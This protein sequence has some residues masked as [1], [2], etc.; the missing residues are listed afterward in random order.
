LDERGGAAQGSEAVAVGAQ[1]ITMLRDPLARAVSQFEH[2]RSRGRFRGPLPRSDHRGSG[3]AD[4]GD[5]R[6]AALA[7]AVLRQLASPQTCPQLETRPSRQCASLSN[8]AKC[9]ANGWCGLFQDHQVEC[10]AGAASF[11]SDQRA[12]KRRSGDQL[13]CAAHRTLTSTLAFVGVVEHYEASV[14]LLLHTFRVDD[15]FNEC[16]RS[17]SHGGG[18]RGERCAL[19]ALRTDAN[20]EGER[21]TAAATASPVASSSWGSSGYLAAYL[22]DPLLLAALYE[23]HRADCELYSAALELFARR[24]AWMERERGLIPGTFVAAVV[25][26]LPRTS[27]HRAGSSTRSSSGA[28]DF[29]DGV[30]DSDTSSGNDDGSNVGSLGNGV[31]GKDN[32][33]LGLLQ[34]PLCVRAAAAYHAL[35]RNLTATG[36]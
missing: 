8:P 9:A 24:L 1:P 7:R 11:S 34:S 35:Q 27:L 29:S 25:Q 31:R 5:G 6:R 21:A 2:H 20:S 32:R 36:V 13:L 10:L 22:S 12:A 17:D 15:L 33:P 23:G 28:G 30:G 19:L 18:E 4:D 16:C 26:P 3:D 14:C